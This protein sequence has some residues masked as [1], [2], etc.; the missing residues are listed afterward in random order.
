MTMLDPE[1][2]PIPKGYA[3]LFN[4]LGHVVGGHALKEMEA[5][6]RAD[7]ISRRI[8]AM[9]T[10]TSAGLLLKLRVNEQRANPTN[11]I[12]LRRAAIPGCQSSRSSSILEQH[13]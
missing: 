3:L 2:F 6:L 9:P 4:A 5:L 10:R 1:G 13:F 11:Q 7:R 12:G 8:I